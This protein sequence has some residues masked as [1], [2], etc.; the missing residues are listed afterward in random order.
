MDILLPFIRDSLVKNVY[1]GKFYKVKYIADPLNRASV[2]TKLLMFYASTTSQTFNGISLRFID[3]TQDIAVPNGTPPPVDLV[4]P[5][6]WVLI[7]IT[8]IMDI[9]EIDVPE[10]TQIS[11]NSYQ[12]FFGEHFF[13]FDQIKNSE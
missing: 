10:E 7:P 13:T 9:V 11:L 1:T 5:N 6:F 12:Q 8:D 2:T 4:N 3:Y